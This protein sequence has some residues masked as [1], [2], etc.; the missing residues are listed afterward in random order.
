MTARGAD[1]RREKSRRGRERQGAKRRPN[2][3]RPPPPTNPSFLPPSLVSA[4][5]RLATA[6]GDDARAPGNAARSTLAGCCIRRADFLSPRPFFFRTA[7]ASAKSCASAPQPRAAMSRIAAQEGRLVYVGNLPDDIREREVCCERPGLLGRAR[8]RG[9]D[10]AGLGR[11]RRCHSGRRAR[12]P[13]RRV[14][15][16]DLARADGLFRSCPLCRSRTFS[17]SMAASARST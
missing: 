15:A 16:A 6:R 14:F 3:R 7:F 5:P 9:P 10:Q 1:A 11:R 13:A 4:S 2:V 17:S 8:R 12:S